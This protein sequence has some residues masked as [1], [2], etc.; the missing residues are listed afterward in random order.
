MIHTITITVSDHYEAEVIDELIHEAEEEGIIDFDFSYK[1]DSK[2]TGADVPSL[3][4][5]QA[6]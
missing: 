6:D 5:L 2:E 3:L 4:K 1:V